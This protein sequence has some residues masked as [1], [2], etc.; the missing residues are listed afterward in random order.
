MPRHMIEGDAAGGSLGGTYPNPT[1]G[2]GSGSPGGST[3]QVQFN[4]AGSFG[5]DAGLVYD[6]TTDTLTAGNLTLT[7]ALPLTQGGTGATSASAARTALGL[8]SLATQSGT[9]SGTSSGTNTGDQT[10]TLT[11]DVTGSG[12]GSFAATLANSGVSANTY[13]SSTQ[14]PVFAVDA[15]GRITSVTNTTITGGSGSVSPD[16]TYGYS[17]PLVDFAAGVDGYLQNMMSERQFFLAY[18][19]GNQMNTIG[20]EAATYGTYTFVNTNVSTEGPSINMTQ[21]SAGGVTGLGCNFTSF[22]AGSSALLWTGYEFKSGA[23]YPDASYNE[24]GASTG[25]RIFVGMTSNTSPT[26]QGN[27][28]TPTGSFAMFRRNHTNGGA[29]DTNW[30][31]MTRDGTT[32]NTTDT[33]M[34]FAV[35]KFYKFYIRIAP[36]GSTIYWRIENVTDSTSANGTTTTNLPAATTPLCPSSAIYTVNATARAFRFKTTQVISG[37]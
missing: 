25:T 23:F 7:N 5:G 6:K 31:F 24:A 15:K 18:P 34:A 2:G 13:G 11:G 19:R 4:D 26:T 28:D 35:S 30:Q 16:T 1:G 20:L 10:I 27:S 36:G 33:G 29:Q 14:V 21:S 17:A 3:T 9:F 12:T 37:V 22:V 32:Q 8:G